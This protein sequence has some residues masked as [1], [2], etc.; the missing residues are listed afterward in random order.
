VRAHGRAEVL[1]LV[2][3]KGG[4]VLGLSNAL[5]RLKKDAEE[6][7]AARPLIPKTYLHKPYTRTVSVARVRARRTTG[8]RCAGEAAQ[9]CCCASREEP[10]CMR[11]L[12]LFG[13]GRQRPQHAPLVPAWRPAL[14]VCARCA[15][16]GSLRQPR[17]RSAA[18]RSCRLRPRPRSS[19]ARCAAARVR[20]RGPRRGMCLVHRARSALALTWQEPISHETPCSP[21][22]LASSHGSWLCAAGRRRW[23]ARR[24]R[25]CLERM[26][27]LVK[28]TFSQS[29]G[30]DMF[31]VSLPLTPL[32]YGS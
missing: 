9:L 5:V 24:Q 17:R 13:A 8:D 27:Y 28:D 32:L 26:H 29:D 3:A 22:M 20:V 1:T 23:C 16:P 11:M 21:A 4:E 12:H 14:H 2:Q 19:T 18:T 6:R 7:R 30:G 15:R 10:A 25:A 31:K